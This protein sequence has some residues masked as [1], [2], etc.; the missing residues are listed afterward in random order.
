[1]LKTLVIGAVMLPSIALAGQ[2]DNWFSDN[3]WQQAT[4][5]QVTTCIVENRVPT[6]DADAWTTPMQIAAGA[7]TRPD[8]IATLS[9]ATFGVETTDSLGFTPMHIA[10]RY[11][12]S[13][14]IVAALINAGQ[15]INAVTEDGSTPL[16][17]AAFG[18]ENV[19]M[20]SA[21]IS[22]GADLNALD[23][24]GRT[25]LHIASA[26]SQ[27]PEVIFMLVEAG[28]SVVALDNTGKNP[29]DYFE[30]NTVLTGES[31]QLVLQAAVE[32]RATNG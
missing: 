17:V 24:N 18:N 26:F 25:P 9:I 11:N 5:E 7:S 27:N 14:A 32:A 21:L 6:G 16:H 22:S 31:L 30:S 2:C 15:N 1:M 13:P 28:A 20:L 3:F 10:A 8:L 4:S 29:L 12:E 23:A 19:A